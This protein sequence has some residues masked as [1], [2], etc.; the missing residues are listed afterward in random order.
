MKKVTAAVEKWTIPT[1]P[2]QEAE[3]MPMFAETRHHQNTTGNPYPSRVVQR[4]EIRNKTDMEY[5]II[6]LEND[7]IRICIIPALGGKVFEAYDKIN[8]YNFLYR[9]HVIKPALIGAFGAWTSGGLEFNWPFHHRPSTCM[10]VDFAL[11][12]CEDGSAVCWLSECDPADR[13]KGMVGIVLRPDASYFETRVKITNRTDMAHSFL[14]WENGAVR[15]HDKYRIIFPP[16]VTWV[17]HHYDRDHTT[18]P[19]ATGRYGALNFTEPTDVSWLKNTRLASS[20]FAAP[21]KYDFFGGY[22]YAADCGTI[23][24]ADHYKSPGKKMFTWGFGAN[25]DNWERQLTDSDGKYCELMAGSYTDDQPDFSWLEPYETKT[26]SQFWYPIRKTGKV[27]FANLNAAVTLDREEEKLRV[28]VTKEVREAAIVLSEAGSGKVILSETFS[29]KPCECQT[30]DISLTDGLYCLRIADSDENELLSYNEE[31]PDT[32]HIPK[33]NPGIPTPDHLHSAQDCYLA[34]AHIDLYRDI[35]YK[36]DAYY[37]EALQYDPC[38]LP[39]LTGLGEYYLR[40]GRLKEAEE[41]LT[42]AM[43]VQNPYDSNPKDGTVGYLLGLTYLRSGKIDQA[44]DTLC[45][46]AWSSSTVSKAMTLIAGIDGQRGQYRKMLQHADEALDKESHNPLAGPYAVW[47]LYKLGCTDAA[48]ERIREILDYDRLNH[49]ARYTEIRMAGWNPEEFYD[50]FLMN[51]NP[52][53]TCLDVALDLQKAGLTQEAVLVLEGL[54]KY[55]GAS[56]MALYTLG[57]LLCELKEKDR[58]EDCFREAAANPIVDVFPYRLEEMDVLKKVITIRPEDGTAYYLLGCLLY[59]KRQ[60]EEASQCWLEAVRCSPEFYIP[61]RNLAVASFSHLRKPDDALRYIRE[62]VERKP[63]EQLLT[64]AGFLMAACGISAEE[65]VMF[66]TQHFPENCGD[67]Y[68]L[69]LTKAYLADGKYD[70]AMH[71][72]LDHEFTPG[73]GGEFIIAEPY[74]FSRFAPGRIALAEGDPEK[75]LQYF[76]DALTLPENLHAG[77]WN[78]A[79]I[80]PFR[81]YQAEALKQLGKT[82]Q[83]QKLIDDMLQI[84]NS[85]MWRMGGEFQYYAAM[86]QKLSGRGMEADRLMRDA[87]LGWEA[88]L[89]DRRYPGSHEM[90]DRFFYRSYIQ[91]PMTLKQADLYSM[92][93]YGMLYMGKKEEA[94]AC[95]ARSLSFNPDNLK[96]ALELKFL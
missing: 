59:D 52:S 87:V 8:D 20:Y 3:V 13:T 29:L 2:L 31:V 10:P 7:Y 46:A 36:P 72:M 76:E 38:H 96:A 92:L 69:E 40:T 56:T 61:Y 65:R 28:N 85:G 14:W 5:D 49:L 71:T 45:K 9:Q 18:Y 58:A 54:R 51:S 70:E 88:E 90:N 80:V 62:A 83:A 43:A 35:T 23:H 93:G 60:Y 24:V 78:E 11:E 47:A 16:D 33:N 82:E 68:I 44:Y 30:Y 89:A 27:S 63:D 73:E 17:H 39:S 64:E 22:D 95:F 91:D 1:Y 41:Y 81:Y 67:N 57:T 37:L 75:A 4:A 94:K 48:A 66:L 6:R 74:M 25:A 86:L 15:I 79:V 77:F 84:D 53:Q 12:E 26:F 55:R 34:G 19:L 42:K 21:S 50:S 32:L